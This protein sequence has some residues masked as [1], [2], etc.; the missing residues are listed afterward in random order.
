MLP[1]A[2]GASARHAKAPTG[3]S[4]VPALVALSQSPVHWQS[5]ALASSPKPPG[6]RAPSL[7]SGMVASAPRGWPVRLVSNVGATASAASATKRGTLLASSGQARSPPRS[8]GLCA[9]RTDRPRVSGTS[10]GPRLTHRRCAPPGTVC[11]APGGRGGAERPALALAHPPPQAPPQQTRRGARTPGLDV[12]PCLA[13]SPQR[14][15]PPGDGRHAVRYLARL[16]ATRTPCGG[17]CMPPRDASSPGPL[18]SDRASS[19]HAHRSQWSLAG[20]PA[21]L[22]TGARPRNVSAASVPGPLWSPPQSPCRLLAGDARRHWSRCVLCLSSTNAHARCSWRIKSGQSL[23]AAG[24]TFR[25]VLRGLCHQWP[26][27]T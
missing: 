16:L 12:I 1:Y 11:P 19:G 4:T 26:C 24:N 7:P 22:D 18:G 3:S 23:R 15:L 14:P 13:P 21:R 8:G 5:T 9:S 6:R 20:A 2:N 27:S 10:G 25:L 17:P